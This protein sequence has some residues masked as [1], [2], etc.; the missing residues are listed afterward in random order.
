MSRAE[1]D[2]YWHCPEFEDYRETVSTVRERVCMSLQSILSKCT[3]LLKHWKLSS[4][5][6][7]PPISRFNQLRKI[8]LS[9]WPH[10]SSS[11]KRSIMDILYDERKL[12]G[13]NVAMSV[14][15]RA[16]V[17]ALEARTA[18]RCCAE[19]KKVDERPLNVR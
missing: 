1:R 9:S 17:D 6:I 15:I 19:V 3:S 8:A 13:L 14:S 11:L 5:Q 10:M 4:H 16:K 7:P 12:Y 18:V 2:W